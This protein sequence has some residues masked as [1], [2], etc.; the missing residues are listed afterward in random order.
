MDIARN[1]DRMSTICDVTH[2]SKKLRV[3]GRLQNSG[4]A[5]R[6]LRQG[7]LRAGPIPAQ[8]CGP[9]GST[10]ACH[11]G[12]GHGGPVEREARGEPAAPRNSVWVREV[13]QGPLDVPVLG[14]VLRMTSTRWIPSTVTK[15]PRS[16]LQD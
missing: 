16:T 4:T 14:H 6:H 2:A 11:G 7:F 3:L 5:R 15:T 8:S 10:S 1:A 9:T 13:L 12:A